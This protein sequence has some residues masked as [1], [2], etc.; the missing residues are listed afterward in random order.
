[1]MTLVMEMLGK[2]SLVFALGMYLPLGLTTPILS[3]RILSHL[4]NK[5]AEAKGGKAGHDGFAS[6]E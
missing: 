5:R 6:A 3:G 4:V 2:S 1:M